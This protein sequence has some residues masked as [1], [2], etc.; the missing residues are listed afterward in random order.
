MIEINLNWLQ[1]KTETTVRAVNIQCIEQDGFYYLVAFDGNLCLSCKIN[2][3]NET[4][5]L[6]FENN[7]KI[8]CNKTPIQQKPFGDNIGFRA[9]LLGINQTALANTL[10]NIDLKM[11]E[12]RYINGAKLILKNHKFGDTID[13]QIVDKDNVLGMGSNL[14]LDEFVSNWNVSEDKQDQGDYIVSYLARIPQNL[15]IRL[16]YT[17]TGNTDVSVCLNLYLHKKT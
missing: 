5:H 4:D 16:V 12:D 17:S 2:K 13:F 6:E 3:D 1:F 7:Y 15:Y 14:V 11:T 10:S 9:R 8:L